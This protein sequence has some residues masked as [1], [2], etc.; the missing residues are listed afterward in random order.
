MLNAEH[1]QSAAP[2]FTWNGLSSGFTSSLE[3]DNTH[4][5]LVSVAERKSLACLSRDLS[6]HQLH[7]ASGLNPIVQGI[8]LFTAPVW[9]TSAPPGISSWN[10]PPR[11]CTPSAPRVNRG[12]PAGRPVSAAHAA[13]P[14]PQRPSL[15]SVVPRKV[16]SAGEPL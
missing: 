14:G 9:L 5:T 13:L 10:P 11:I 16:W 15:N 1:K 6:T 2:V 7:D 8:Q 4:L 12:S 3:H